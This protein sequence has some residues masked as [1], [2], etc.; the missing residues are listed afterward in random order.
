MSEEEVLLPLNSIM[1]L[2]I[3]LAIISLVT[4]GMIALVKIMRMKN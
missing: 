4:W 1:S 2:V 3:S